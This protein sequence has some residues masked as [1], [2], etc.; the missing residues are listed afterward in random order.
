MPKPDPSNIASFATP[1]ELGAWFKAHHAK[2]NELWIK[3]YKK[4]SGVT[5]VTWNEVVIEALCWGWIDGVKQSLDEQ[6]YLQRITPR[7]AR[8]SWSKRNTEHVERLIA[9]NRMMP[10]GLVQVEAAQSDGRWQNAY[11][12]SE[13]EVPIDFLSALAKRPVANAFFQTLNKSSRY[14]IA[15]GLQSA[16]KPETR[17]RRFEKYMAMLENE[18]KP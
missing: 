4:G 12:A 15:Y 14:I 10:P 11:V 5:S 7:T 9:E 16:K 6:A 18:Q 2:Q 1:L 17:L 8:S 13:I 3:I